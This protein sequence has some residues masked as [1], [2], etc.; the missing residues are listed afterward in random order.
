MNGR[1]HAPLVRL[2]GTEFSLRSEAVRAKRQSGF[3]IVAAMFLLVVLAALGTFILGVSSMN[4]MARAYDMQ[5]AQA[6]QAARAGI[7]WGLYKV[8]QS[9][10]GCPATTSFSPPAIGGFTV[11]V[12]CS[13]TATDE[14]GTTVTVFSLTAT[15]CNLAAGGACPG[16]VGNNYVERQLTAVAAR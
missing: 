16:S 3:S 1:D 9:G 8:L 7:E 4:H 2:H 14:L 13:S 11:T 6:Y 5:G 15:A 10:P 12:G